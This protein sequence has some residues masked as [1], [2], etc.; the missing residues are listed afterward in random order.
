MIHMRHAAFQRFNAG[1]PAGGGGGVGEA[2]EK[3]MALN[4]EC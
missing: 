1:V 3:R 2:E 4:T